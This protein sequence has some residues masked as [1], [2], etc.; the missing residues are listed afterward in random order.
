MPKGKTLCKIV[1]KSSKG[2]RHAES[3]SRD[4]ESLNTSL[5][6]QYENDVLVLGNC[7]LQVFA[8]DCWVIVILNVRKKWRRIYLG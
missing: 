2:K 6:H 5:F 4:V 1:F 3:H 7:Q 8:L